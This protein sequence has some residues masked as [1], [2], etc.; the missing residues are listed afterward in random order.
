MIANFFEY[1]TYLSFIGLFLLML[2][3]DRQLIYDDIMYFI[4][5]HNFVTSALNIFLLYVSLPITIPFSII[6]ITKK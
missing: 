5:R 4:L 2:R 1:Y 3:K 6:N